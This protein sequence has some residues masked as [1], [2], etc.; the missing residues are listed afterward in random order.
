VIKAERTREKKGG[1]KEGRHV[2]ENEK[3]WMK[4]DRR[5]VRVYGCY[6]WCV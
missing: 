3:E 5:Q 2:K 4:E 6:Q 1:S